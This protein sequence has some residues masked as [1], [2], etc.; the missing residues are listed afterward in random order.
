M[1]DDLCIF[2]YE[3]HTLKI[4]LK[5]RKVRWVVNYH[6][7]TSRKNVEIISR[8]ISSI[9]IMCTAMNNTHRHIRQMPKSLNKACICNFLKKFG[10]FANKNVVLCKLQ[11]KKL[12]QISLQICPGSQKYHGVTNVKTKTLMLEPKGWITSSYWTSEYNL[13]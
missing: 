7:I 13:F 1:H 11:R 9:F 12:Q 6:T 2:L 8:Y 5:S 10:R 3:C 4:Y